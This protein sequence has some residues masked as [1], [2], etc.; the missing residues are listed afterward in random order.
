MRTIPLAVAALASALLLTAC[1]SGSGGGSSDSD[2]KNG[3]ACSFDG[4]GV[5]VGPASTAPSAGD[6][7]E[8]PVSLTNQSKPC[9]LDGFAGA[10]LEGGG[11]KVALAT[12]KGAKAQKLTLAKGDAASFT[13]TYVRGA[14]G[15]KLS[16]AATKLVI[17]LPG[18]SDTASYKWS[19]GPV[20]GKTSVSD[21]DA[22]VSAF[23]Q[24][25][26]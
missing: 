3:S 2:S 18:S 6:T 26:D 5:Q 17:T 9:T 14:A 13:I 4:V 16:L 7:G 15:G 1:D 19:Y 24:A 10:S 20:Q 23:T 21:S 12:Q 11:T 22:S 8:V 25:G